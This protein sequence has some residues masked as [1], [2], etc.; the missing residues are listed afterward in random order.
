MSRRNSERSYRR[1]AQM[2]KI[3]AMASRPQRPAKRKP[4][5]SIESK[6]QG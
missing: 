3:T 5:S 4:T 1:D 2:Q 6:R